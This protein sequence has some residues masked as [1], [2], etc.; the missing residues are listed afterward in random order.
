MEN[1]ELLGNQV[2][3]FF[4]Q[5]FSGSF[6]EASISLKK[7][8]GSEAGTQILPIPT[9]APSEIPRLILNIPGVVLN[10]A[11]NRVD[12]F[13]PFTNNQE[14]IQKIVEIIIKDLKISIGRIGFVANYFMEGDLNTIKNIVAPEKIDKLNLKEISLRINTSVKIGGYSCNSIQSIQNG[15]IEKGNVNKKSGIIINRDVNTLNEDLQNH[16]FDVFSAIS[17]IKNANI[18]AE[19]LIIL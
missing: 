17:F 9:N 19:Q 18:E 11:K 2:G 8:L 1:K 6:E 7:V 4:K 16:K 14:N 3:L 15:E 5:D 12:I 13:A 10:F